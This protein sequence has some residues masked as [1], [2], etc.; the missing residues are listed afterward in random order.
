MEWNWPAMEPAASRWL[1]R[2]GKALAVAIVNASV[3]TGCQMAIIDATLPPPIIDRLIDSVRA[4]IELL[5]SLPVQVQKGR[6]GVS[7][8]A[9]GAAALLMYR[10]YFS[11][12]WEHF[13]SEIH[14]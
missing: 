10:T 3:T 7:A 9:R 11:G 5:P 2:A 14:A 13:P 4:S 1:E 8:A 12:D 6:A